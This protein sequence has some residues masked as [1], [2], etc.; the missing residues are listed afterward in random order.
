MNDLMSLMRVNTFEELMSAYRCSGYSF[1]VALDGGAGQGEAT[2]EILRNMESDAVCHA[3]EPFPGNHRFFEQLNDPRVILHKRA[4]ANDRGQH[5]FL[6]TSVVKADS[7][8]GAEGK[9]GYSSVGHLVHGA[10]NGGVNPGGQ[11]LSVETVRADDFIDSAADFIKLDLQGGELPA[12]KGMERH[13]RN[14]YFAWVEF[15]MQEG[16]LDYLES[17][18]CLV[19][20]TEY[21][22]IGEPAGQVLD[23]FEVSQDNY[24]LSTGR[25][26][27]FG[28]RKRPW[29]DCRTE[30]H[31]FRKEF[32][33]VQTDLVCVNKG[34]YPAF[35]TS[36]NTLCRMQKGE[37][38]A[39]KRDPVAALA[40]RHTVLAKVELDKAVG[41]RDTAVA[42]RDAALVER[43][44]ALVE[45]D[46]AL[47]ERD[48]ALA[49]RNAAVEGRDAALA[50]RDAAVVER[51][52]V[53]RYPWKYLGHAAKLRTG[54]AQ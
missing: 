41:E 31:T 44:A 47:V 37:I 38:E 2:E 54:R 12:L 21:L 50:E 46:A 8:W 16:L 22:F 35:L 10:P 24:T 11:L 39:A 23:W 27:W 40:E 26:A 20:D 49:E 19:F 32:G 3:F 28:Y 45:R 25:T 30:F 36:I 29:K 51:D 33:L 1:R 43:D 52:R 4:L 7:A 15:S 6:V 5:D 13:F 18:G 42:E 53:T 48:A 34:Q 9:E 17:L 14:C